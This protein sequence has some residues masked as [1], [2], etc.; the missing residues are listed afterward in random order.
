MIIC[1]KQH[2]CIG[3]ALC[4]E[5]APEYFVMDDDGMAVLVNGTQK[6]I[7]YSAEAHAMDRESIQRAVAG[8]PVNIIRLDG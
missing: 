3:C 4:V 8:C 6:N 1:H 2:E 5:E 7:F